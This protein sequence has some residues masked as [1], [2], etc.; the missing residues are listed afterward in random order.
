MQG[1]NQNILT[2]TDKLLAF[3]KNMYITLENT[4]NSQKDIY[5]ITMK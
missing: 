5:K 2:S 1:K 3:Q 4:H